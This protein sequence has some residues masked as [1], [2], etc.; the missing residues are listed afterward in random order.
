MAGQRGAV[1]TNLANNVKVRAGR[2]ET[3]RENINEILI[4]KNNS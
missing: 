4:L 2:K 1:Y 3:K